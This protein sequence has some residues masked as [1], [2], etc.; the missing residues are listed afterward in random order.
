M[1]LQLRISFLIRFLFE[2]VLSCLTCADYIR[3][4]YGTS[5]DHTHGNDRT[6][7]NEHG[8]DRVY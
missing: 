1:Q 7:G 4:S 5:T 6:Y 8:N 2:G 3:S